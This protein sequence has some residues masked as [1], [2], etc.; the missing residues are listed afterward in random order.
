MSDNGHNQDVSTGDDPPP[1]YINLRLEPCAECGE[2]VL[3]AMTVGAKPFANLKWTFRKSETERSEEG[4]FHFIV[5][6]L[7]I[8][9]DPRLVD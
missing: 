9:N 2:V 4:D 6:M 1:G 3:K 8:T 7:H 5:D